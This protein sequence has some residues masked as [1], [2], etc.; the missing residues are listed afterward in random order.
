M[1]GILTKVAILALTMTCTS[2]SVNA[3]NYRRGDYKHRGASSTVSSIAH[4]FGGGY[5]DYRYH[6]GNYT[7]IRLGANSASL[8]FDGTGGINKNSFTGMNFGFVNGFRMAPYV[9]LYLESG[10]LYTHK[11]V[12][13]SKNGE[14]LKV[15]MHYFEVPLVFKYKI[16]LDDGLN[17]ISLQPFFGGY[18]SLGF[19]GKTKDF[20]SYTSSNTFGKNAFGNFDGGLRV[21]CGFEFEN[22]YLEVAYDRGLANV[23]RD[24][25][26]HLG[27]DNFN[28][29]IN[30]STLSATIGF[31][32]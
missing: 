2:I 8:L 11:G 27:Y 25:F 24:N 28:D 9:P 20:S 14:Q 5:K 7:G 22:L 30:T 26:H 17:N 1:K 12:K 3:Q 18:A 13:G 31:N 16:Y 15:S 6:D 21:G 29:Q 19:A 10:I 4:S 23:A 32:F